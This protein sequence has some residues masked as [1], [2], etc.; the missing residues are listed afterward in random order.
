MNF[1]NLKT[2]DLHT[3]IEKIKSNGS[4]IIILINNPI[5]S[6]LGHLSND[7]KVKYY[8][9]GA[10]ILKNFFI[11]DIT[12]LSNSFNNDFDLSIYGLNVSG[13]VKL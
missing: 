8:G 11:D 5:L 7:E 10:Q 9:L 3:S 4:G 2:K 12:V 6:E 1:N 13:T